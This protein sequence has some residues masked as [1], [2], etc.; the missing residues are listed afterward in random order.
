MSLSRSLKREDWSIS[1]IR[2]EC[3]KKTTFRGNS[4]SHCLIRISA[5]FFFQI[6]ERTEML[7]HSARG[8]SLKRTKGHALLRDLIKRYPD[9]R[10]F[11]QND[12]SS[13]TAFSWHYFL[14]YFKR[15]AG[16]HKN[17]YHVVNARLRR[18]K[19]DYT[20]VGII[21]IVNQVI[22]VIIHRIFAFFT[23]EISIIVF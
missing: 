18:E 7:I 5:F 1:V 20:S 13:N 16:W 9:A 21:K 3:E 11:A 8:V 6:N 12:V 17:V 22:C 4:L 14:R 23:R 15:I 10:T 19:I 2:Y